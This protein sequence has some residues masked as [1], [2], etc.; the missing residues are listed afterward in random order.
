[1]KIS[2]VIPVFNDEEHLHDSLNSLLNQ[3]FSDFEVIC[4]NDGSTD[5]SSTIL[6]EFKNKFSNFVILNQDNLGS[7]AARN[8]GIKHASGEYVAFLDSDDMFLDSKSLDVMIDVA[9]KNNANMVSANIMGINLEGNLVKTYN[10]PYISNFSVIKPEQ[11]GIPYS[12]YKNIFKRSFILENNIEFPNLKRGQD[13]IFLANI[14][15][16]LDKIYNVP[17]DFY[18]YRY[19]VN[20]SLDKIDSYEKKYDYIK[21]FKDTFDI[22]STD[23]RFNDSL[24]NYIATFLK[25]LSYFDSNKKDI[26]LRNIINDVFKNNK[27]GIQDKIN[28]FFYIPKISVIVPVYNVEE[29]LEESLKNI[30]NQS[31]DDY[32]VLCINDGSTDNSLNILEDF[33]KKHDKIHIIN[34]DNCGCGCARNVGLNN[35]SGEYLYFFD[36]DDIIEKYTLE[37]LYNNAIINDSDIV[38]FKHGLYY[39]SKIDNTNSKYDFEVDNPDVNYDYY[40]FDYN[41]IKHY[42]LN[43]V[44]APW[45]KFYSRNFLESYDDMYF[46]VNVAFDDVVFHVKTILRAKRISYVP[47]IM[48]HYRIEN[49]NSV[50]NTSSNAFDIFRIC[51]IVENFLVENDYMEEFNY[52][53]INFKIYQILYYI[54]SSNSEYYFK[55]AQ[56]EFNKMDIDYIS[57]TVKED[58]ELVISSKNY[59]EY[60]VSRN[61]PLSYDEENIDEIRVINKQLLEENKK[62]KNEN[63]KLSAEKNDYKNKY[64][65]L[66][67]SNS[68]KITQPIRW[69]SASMKKLLKR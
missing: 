4:V 25:Y 55:Y 46:P 23:S 52:E 24:D 62:I 12:F 26:E 9:V 2:V 69:V 45:V 10:L 18:G 7:G 44:F 47:Q 63:D 59:E 17:I 37:T 57:S 38:L 51:D 40:V 53:F 33:A 32:E 65:T 29:Y 34:Q 27:Y 54:I 36:P 5:N 43:S 6:E 42:V 19:S 64:D 50:N 20:D 61:A 31:F 48:Y 58:Y 68:W 14:L 1:M 28:N 41:D 8:N 66:L 39:G 13:P 67:A 22:L 21:H 16:K 15:T 30:L 3:S 49:P 60:R 11:Y 35:A 56:N